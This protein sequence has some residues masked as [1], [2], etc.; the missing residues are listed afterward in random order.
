MIAGVRIRVSASN[1]RLAI[2]DAN[3]KFEGKEEALVSVVVDWL[4]SQ[5]Q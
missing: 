5:A 3:H 4:Q 2:P 1:T